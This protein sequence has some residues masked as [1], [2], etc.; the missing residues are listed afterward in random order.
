MQKLALLLTT[1]FIGSFAPDGLR[2][3]DLPPHPLTLGVSNGVKT[4]TWPRALLP[5]LDTNR[6][7]VSTNL[8]TFSDI[9]AT[10]VAAAPSGYTYLTTNGLP[11]QFYNLQLI[12]M[13]S[14]ALLTANVLNR[15][16][17]GPTPDDIEA[18]LTGPNAIGP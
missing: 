6:L 13:S 17:Y 16:A 18:V 7:M 12:Q 15:L 9:P 10:N 8:P 14:N 4:V 2:A 5:A 1:V 11:Q 3:D